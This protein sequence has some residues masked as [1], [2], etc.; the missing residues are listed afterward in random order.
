[1][2]TVEDFPGINNL[3]I[4]T[5]STAAANPSFTEH[6]D[7]VDCAPSSQY[8]NGQI[9]PVTT[10]HSVNTK[11]KVYQQRSTVASGANVPLTESHICAS[12]IVSTVN[13]TQNIQSQMKDNVT[14]I[15]I[16]RVYETDVK[17]NTFI[18]KSKKAQLLP[19]QFSSEI[20]PETEAIMAPATDEHVTAVDRP[21]AR[22][23]FEYEIIK[24][25]SKT[26]TGETIV[27]P[28][29]QTYRAETDP[30]QSAT[31]PVEQP[32]S[33]QTDHAAESDKPRVHFAHHP[34]EDSSRVAPTSDSEFEYQFVTDPLKIR[35]EESVDP[36]YSYHPVA[37]ESAK[38][39]DHSAGS[40]FRTPS[41][42]SE[43]QLRYPDQSS[44]EMDS[45]ESVEPLD[46]SEDDPYRIQSIGTIKPPDQFEYQTV[47]MQH[48]PTRTSQSDA[49][50]TAPSHIT[51][52]LASNKEV[53]KYEDEYLGDS[54]SV[55]DPF[56]QV[57]MPV[58]PAAISASMQVDE[59]GD[60]SCQYRTSTPVKVHYLPEEASIQQSV[61]DP[62]R[63][64]PLFP[65]NIDLRSNTF[66]DIKSD[67][68]LPI[69]DSIQQ[70]LIDFRINTDDG[71]KP[72][73]LSDC[74]DENGLIQL[75]NKKEK[76][77]FAQVVDTGLLDHCTVLD[78]Q[79]A[80]EIKIDQLPFETVTCETLPSIS[81]SDFPSTSHT[82]SLTQPTA[83]F[84]ISLKNLS[85]QSTA[86]LSA[87]EVRF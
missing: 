54:T 85:K 29:R 14:Q 2:K 75:P 61:D 76:W 79:Q 48:P 3:I 74:I 77:T 65:I 23:E 87:A 38:P 63:L 41:S 22:D 51:Y 33:Y 9:V 5:S 43:P 86:D 81:T 42:I 46:R 58:H 27:M 49:V 56:D 73:L 83:N 7:M 66:H 37:I 57:T 35:S 4:T 19:K 69:T 78:K 17:N 44:F 13:V 21:E 10:D 47:I 8:S 1:M 6:Y 82:Q 15:V 12:S 20:Q 45:I 32:G 68:V 55:I 18:V 52:N 24:D 64:I 53:F 50:Q 39:C 40:S 70:N 28:E 59:Q 11:V 25:P 72:V 71:S 80:R 67:R 62:K 60:I 36:K 30:Y 84:P 16:N 34:S 26:Y 31:A